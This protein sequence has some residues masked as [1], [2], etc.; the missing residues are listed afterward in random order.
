MCHGPRAPM[1]ESKRSKDTQY[2]NPQ[3]ISDL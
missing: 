2:R 1:M 3:W